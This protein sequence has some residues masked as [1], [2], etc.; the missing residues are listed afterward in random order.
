M[1]A[2]IALDPQNRRHRRQAAELLV[3]NF[4]AW[5]AMEIARA[6]VST[7]LAKNRVCLVAVDE[8]DRVVGLV[9]GL[10]DY[11]GNV[12]ELHPLVVKKSEQG[13]GIGRQLVAAIERAAKA[14]GAITMMLGTDDESGATTLSGCDLYDGL[15]KRVSE[16]QNLKNHPYS[17][18]ENCGYSI[19]GVVP[20]ANGYGRPDILMAKRLREKKSGGQKGER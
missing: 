1:A 13:R 12:W 4:A 8:N 5:P 9:G 19:I 14:R 7:L 18:Y 20:D 3:E 6:E 11:D 10:P 16:I 2:I 17:F 15:W